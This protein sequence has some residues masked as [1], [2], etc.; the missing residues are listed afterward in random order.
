V[1]VCQMATWLA[2]ATS[3]PL[4]GSPRPPPLSS[5]LPASA[6]SRASW[7]ASAPTPPLPHRYAGPVRSAPQGGCGA[8]E[9]D[10]TGPDG[11]AMNATASDDAERLRSSMR[12]LA[13]RNELLRAQLVSAS[14]AACG[15]ASVP[16][17]SAF[18]PEV[19]AGTAATVSQHDVEVYQRLKEK[20][21]FLLTRRG[22]IEAEAAVAASQA[23]RLSSSASG[24]G[25]SIAEVE[26]A[27]DTA[28]AQLHAAECAGIEVSRSAEEAETRLAR[29]QE[30]L[31]ELNRRRGPVRASWTSSANVGFGESFLEPEHLDT[32][33]GQQEADFL[34]KRLA[35]AR[36]KRD[37]CVTKL[38]A[39]DEA[40][41]CRSNEIVE[42]KTQKE[43]V[44][45][46]HVT[47][48]EQTTKCDDEL[49]GI[50][51]VNRTKQG[52][53]E[54]KHRALES[55]E[56]ALSAEA[57]DVRDHNQRLEEDMGRVRAELRVSENAAGSLKTLASEKK[58]QLAA[59]RCA[60]DELRKHTGHFHASNQ[61]DIS[62]KREAVKK[63]EAERDALRAELGVTDVA[64]TS[65]SALGTV[66]SG[67]LADYAAAEQREAQRK[68]RLESTRMALEV[69]RQKT[70]AAT[71]TPAAQQL[72]ISQLSTKA[73][74]LQR[75]LVEE[76]S[77]GT[78]LAAEF[79]QLKTRRHG[80]SASPARGS[81]RGS[82]SPQLQKGGQK[83][84]G[85]RRANE[86]L[87]QELDELRAW[88]S[89]AEGSI[90]RMNGGLRSAQARYQEQ[91]KYGQELEA[92]ILKMGQ[93]AL[94]VSK[95]PE[96]GDAEFLASSLVQH[97]PVPPEHRPALGVPAAEPVCQY[98]PFQIRFV[99]VLLRNGDGYLVDNGL[100]KSQLT[101]L[102]CR[103]SKNMED[104]GEHVID[105]GSTVYGNVEQSEDGVAWLKITTKEPFSIHT[106][107]TVTPHPHAMLP[108]G[109]DAA[110]D[111]RAAGGMWMDPGGVLYDDAVLPG[112]V[113][114]LVGRMPS[115][116]HSPSQFR[117]EQLSSAMP[118]APPASLDR[119]KAG[120]PSK[121]LAASFRA[122]GRRRVAVSQSPS[123]RFVSSAGGGGAFVGG[124]QHRVRGQ[125][126]PGLAAPI[127]AG[128]F[129]SHVGRA[130]TPQR[131]ACLR[132]QPKAAC[133]CQLKVAKAIVP[134]VQPLGGPPRRSGR[135]VSAKL[136]S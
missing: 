103:Q 43:A 54:A 99:P 136:L 16:S 95:L 6:P 67:V 18:R 15:S 116:M 94:D 79:Q 24:I 56:R 77:N 100:L 76:R 49:Q 92:A 11:S 61:Q 29:A 19:S 113:G 84:A 125:S 115:A 39:C 68:E 55:E 62:A 124:P 122:G 48:R 65:S 51:A 20:E 38:R 72:L 131:R 14:G 31:A 132:C 134:R 9:Y 123:T 87:T 63:L 32:A 10:L 114:E 133:R 89:Q 74:S 108:V 47:L 135:T 69:E 85:W 60:I 53:F 17:S 107:P 44:T 127:S 83:P 96:P 86:R 66:P 97:L 41:E 119:K 27:R 12:E 71:T 34:R 111:A 101:G 30:E 33:R 88:R 78:Q 105:F 57:A 52:S 104:R 120:P 45:N 117:Y 129:R 102:T 109:T 40:I 21:A 70:R 25:R 46:T 98:L 130:P 58:G 121:N 81:R 126:C 22:A 35:D 28:A 2:A 3:L 23:L 50:L 82:G 106:K 36:E 64:A 110:P 5:P 128:I 37:G 90:Q 59:R 91:A 7:P 13:Q 26:T 1:C 93:K 118:V 75:Q 8:S 4:H 80:R 42:L 112:G 73:E